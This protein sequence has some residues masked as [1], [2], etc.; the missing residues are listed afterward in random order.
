[1]TRDEW[2]KWEFSLDLTDNPYSE[3]TKRS[4]DNH[5]QKEKD[6]GWRTSHVESIGRDS[7]LN[8]LYD[9]NRN[10]IEG[11]DDNEF[12]ISNIVIRWCDEN[13]QGR[14]AYINPTQWEFEL[15]IDALAF[16]L[17]WAGE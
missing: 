17:R 15:E 3:H 4:Y 10:G 12:G 11:I 13:C 1:M 5:L 16:K 8:E 2:L 14:T 9:P 7:F 6:R